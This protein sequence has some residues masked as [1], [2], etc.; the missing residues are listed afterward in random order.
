MKLEPINPAPPV[1]TMEEGVNVMG[2]VFLSLLS[3][4][5]PSVFF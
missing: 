2:K 4:E 5:D 1:T 3:G